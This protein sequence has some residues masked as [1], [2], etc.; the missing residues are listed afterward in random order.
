MHAFY[1]ELTVIKK[2]LVEIIILKGQHPVAG[3][4]M[5]CDKL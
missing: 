1:N 2:I 3:D 4:S 5:E